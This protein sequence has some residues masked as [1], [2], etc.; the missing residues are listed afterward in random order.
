MIAKTC[1]VLFA[2]IALFCIAPRAQAQD[3]YAFQFG[4]VLGHQNS[5]RN[6]LPTPPYFSIYPPV[7]YGAR[8]QRPYGESPF[9]SFPQLR[10]SPDY[11]AVP[12]QVPYRSHSVENPHATHSMPHVKATIGEPVA[13]SVVGPGRIVQILNPF[14]QPQLVSAN[15]E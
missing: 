10:S 2:T 3:P 5:F 11:F 7:Y 13:S 14:A 4:Y 9:A 8:Y 12:K 15:Q 1:L 6:R